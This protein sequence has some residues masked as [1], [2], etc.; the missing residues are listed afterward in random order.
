MFSAQ[1][2]ALLISARK[3]FA[4]SNISWMPEGLFL[5]FM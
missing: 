2:N 1:N 3:D 4:Q 5:N